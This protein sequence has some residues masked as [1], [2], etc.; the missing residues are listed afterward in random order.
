MSF[1][2]KS[3]TGALMKSK[4]SAL[5]LITAIFLNV[6]D[7]KACTNLL[8]TKGAS[9]NNSNMI[10]YSADAGGFMEPLKFLPAKDNA[11]GTMVELY[12]WDSGKYLGKI[13]EAAHTYK[14]VG[15]MNEFQVSI[16]ETTFGG[17][18]E[19][20][21]TTSLID[22]GSMM[23][24]ALQRAKTAREAIKVM[25]QLMQTYGYCSSGESFSVADPNEV[26]IMEVIGKGPG[27]KG[28]VWVAQRIPDGYVAAHA[29]QARIRKI[30]KNDPDNFLYSPDVVDFAI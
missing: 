18:H 21:D 5:I 25:D 3:N 23:Y 12:E 28:S 6:T 1:P 7:S 26:W 17:R 22:Y 13:P 15:N 20:V 4:I 19:L 29:N 16:G 10:S 8:I 30:I 2:E 27:G 11:A 24:L 9:K 14:V